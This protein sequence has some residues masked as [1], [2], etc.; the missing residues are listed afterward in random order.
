[1]KSLFQSLRW[2]IQ[3]WH[4][5]LLLLA[6]GAS[7]FPAYHFARENQMRRIDSE[8]DRMEHDLIHSLM[9]SFEEETEKFRGPMPLEDFVERLHSDPVSIPSD[10]SETYQETGAGSAYFSIRDLN[11]SVLIESKNAPADMEFIPPGESE[12]THAFRS[13]GNRR[14][15]ARTISHG[16]KIVVGRD[17]TPDLDRMR[18]MAGIH[19][20]IGL[21]VWIVGLLGGW[22][23]SGRA[24]R[25]IQTISGTATRIADGNLAERIDPSAM[26]TE[27][28]QLSQVLND[29]FDKLE[30]AFE[31]QRQFT[32]DASHELR[33]PITVI[34][35]ETQRL[36]KR[37]RSNEEYREGI[38]TCSEIAQRMRRLAESLLILA[39]QED[40]DSSKELHPCD[41]SQVIRE[42]ADQLEPVAKEKDRHL[43][44][45]LSPA[46]FPGDPDAVAILV[47][48]LIG[49]AIEHGGNI[50]VRCRVEN[51]E[52]HVRVSDNGP[53][54]PD[55]DLPYIFD[56]FYRVDSARTGGSG[57]SGLGL[58]I[59][60]AIVK[61]HGGTIEV[62][63][64]P[65]GGAAFDLR[66]PATGESA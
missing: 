21:A 7:I 56:R 13:V 2:R 55:A 49:N 59:A 36:L 47:T 46:S 30:A 35:T 62:S 24:I 12:F 53:G 58:A 37:D 48:N 32:A 40:T 9:R 15:I 66:F 28:A 63:N 44:L 14:E 17:I 23:L 8:L 18:A 45:D 43:V 27:L 11:E 19:A 60:R 6:I 52:V 61:N 22:W 25:P 38:Q 65:E 33:T 20:G 54:I 57:H 34:L 5:L 50:R 10:V 29:S 39:R 31:R 64:L 16:L 4:A 1:M 26:D 3:A 42:V 51:G 41:I